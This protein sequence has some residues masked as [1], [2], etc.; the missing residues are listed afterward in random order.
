M[1]NKAAAR[2]QRAADN[3][4]KRLTDAQWVAVKNCY[5]AS[6]AGYL[7]ERRLNLPADM[8]EP[9]SPAYHRLTDPFGIAVREAI[10]SGRAGVA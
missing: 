9:F 7:V 6:G 2:R 10:V 1:A 8:V 3:A 5:H 4:A